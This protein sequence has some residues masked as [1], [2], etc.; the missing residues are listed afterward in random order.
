MNLDL[1]N[2][3]PLNSK[4]IDTL[5]RTGQPFFASIT[6]RNSWTGSTRVEVHCLELRECYQDA[7][8]LYLDVGLY[9]MDGDESGWCLEDYEYF[10]PFDLPATPAP[11]EESDDGNV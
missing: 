4:A 2:W 9:G 3:Q 10:I 11:I 8:S 7:D 5:H 1:E 6:V